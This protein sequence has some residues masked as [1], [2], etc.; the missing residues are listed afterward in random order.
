MTYADIIFEPTYFQV[1][2]SNKTRFY[3]DFNT[4]SFIYFTQKPILDLISRE[5]KKEI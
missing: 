3:K 2:K 4:M 1:D 5:W